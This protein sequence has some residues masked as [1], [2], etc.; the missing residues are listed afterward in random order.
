MSVWFITFHGGKYPCDTPSSPAPS[1]TGNINTLAGWILSGPL[2][3]MQELR[4]SA[5]DKS[6]NLY[7]ANANRKLNQ[8]LQFQP[9]KNGTFASNP[10]NPW[11]SDGLAHPFGLQFDGSGNLYAVNQDPAPKASG[12]V[13]TWYDSKGK[14]KGIF[15]PNPSPKASKPGPDLIEPRGIAWDGNNT[16]YLADEKGNSDGKGKKGSGAVYMYQNNGD[17][18]GAID[19]TDPVHLQ[20][21]QGYL[22]IGS[23]SANTVYCYGASSKK[24]TQ[25]LPSNPGVKIKA[26]SGLAIPGDGYIYV[27]SRETFQVMQFTLNISTTPPSASNGVI[28]FDQL[29]DYPE[30]IR[31]LSV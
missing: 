24:V 10:K 21:S 1:Y 3:Q 2:P 20:Y 31:L 12:P 29:P 18:T 14:Y 27:N 4:G 11:A 7:I 5:V 17:Y 9:T 19:V 6:G 22:F 25:L 16:W 30:F 13:V 26:V 15:V 23:N 8:I 28:F